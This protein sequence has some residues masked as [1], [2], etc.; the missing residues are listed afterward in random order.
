MIHNGQAVEKNNL[1][2]GTLVRTMTHFTF[3]K[4]IQEVLLKL[5]LWKT[6]F[7]T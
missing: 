4:N 5:C 3:S 1:D 6:L 7:T 2:V